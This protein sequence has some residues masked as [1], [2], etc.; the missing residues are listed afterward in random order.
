VI[1]A[2]GPT[3]FWYATRG[4][5][6]AALVLLSAVVVLGLVTSVRWQSERWPRFL[7]QSLH[8]NL[9]LLAVVFLIIHVAA[10]IIDPFAGL[11]VR[12]AIVPVGADYRPLWLGLGVIAFELFLAVMISSLLRSHLG[13]RTWLA[14]HLL[15]Y[16]SW[17]VAVLHSIGTGTDT[18]AIWA[19]LLVIAC[20]AAVAMTLVWRLG[21]GWPRQAAARFGGIAVSLAALFALAAWTATGPLQEGWARTAGTPANLLSG[22][23]PTPSASPTG[24]A[25]GLAPGLNDQLS[26]TV[27][28]GGGM[29]TLTLTDQSTP[30]LQI[31]IVSNP[32]GSA[33]MTITNGGAQVCT[34]P[35]SLGRSVSAQCGS[36]LVGVQVFDRGSGS[37]TGT[38]VTEG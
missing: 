1:A 38:M 25:G 24:P 36:V 32:D 16:A 28:R 29:V 34:A 5:G 21:R 9:S 14:I 30:S 15:A 37:V 6:Y 2:A 7:T 23:A 22:A 12:D 26:G 31:V 20:V 4:S 19:L 10:S 17:P 18:K 13:W 35:A 33:V 27:L 11:S 3:P 8:R